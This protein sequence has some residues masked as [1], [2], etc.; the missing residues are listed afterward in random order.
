MVWKTAYHAEGGGE[1]HVRD[2]RRMIELSADLIDKETLSGELQRRGILEHFRA[3]CGS[4]DF[5]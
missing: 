5:V 3:M 1:K 2:I 4:A